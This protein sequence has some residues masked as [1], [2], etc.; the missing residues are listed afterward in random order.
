MPV[1][2]T[3]VP[4]ISRASMLTI[5]RS[6]RLESQLDHLRRHPEHVR[7]MQAWNTSTSL[8]GLSSG[9]PEP[10]QKTQGLSREN[11]KEVQ[12]HPTVTSARLLTA[13]RLTEAL[14]LT[15]LSAYPV[16]AARA[17]LHRGVNKLTT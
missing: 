3:A 17:L 2:N 16:T 15:P 5:F 11:R 1:S 8:A 14:A 12:W 10:G 6:H 13:G 4:S 7:L 9:C